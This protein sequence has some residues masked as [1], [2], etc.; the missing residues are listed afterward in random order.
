MMSWSRE[1]QPLVRYLVNKRQLRACCLL[2]WLAAIGCGGRNFDV[3]T[4]ASADLAAGGDLSTVAFADFAP[5]KL[6]ENQTMKLQAGGGSRN[7]LTSVKPRYVALT[8]VGDSE[9]YL[10]DLSFLSDVTVSVQ[11]GTLPEKTIAS[12]S[13]FAAGSNAVA[14]D[15][16]A[17]E[18][19]N[20]FRNGDPQITISGTGQAP[21]TL[22]IRAEVVWEI[23]LSSGAILVQ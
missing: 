1:K 20:Y 19:L 7:R 16:D 5:I 4:E 23:D 15:V 17:S 3:M 11:Y 18:V 2:L 6:L 14:L 9:E 8:V 10:Q 12:Q 22:S 13:T 21:N